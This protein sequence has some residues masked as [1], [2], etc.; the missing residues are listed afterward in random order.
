MHS[1]NQRSGMP[2]Q[3]YYPKILHPLTK[4]YLIS[5]SKYF[6]NIFNGFILSQSLKNFI[7]ILKKGKLS[8]KVFTFSIF[9]LSNILGEQG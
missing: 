9:Q 7:I 2:S 3:K 8:D 5:I 1:L 4:K 6:Q